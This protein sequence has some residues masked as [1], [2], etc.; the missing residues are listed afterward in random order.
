MA[1]PAPSANSTA[2]SRPRSVRSSAVDW[3]SPPITST[4]RATPDW[5]NPSAAASPYTKPVHWLR[6]SIAPAVFSSSRCSMKT[7]LPGKNTS[8][9]SV[10]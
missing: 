8:G 2:M 6:M 4:V 5:M 7:P 10:A 1:A 9:F 3:I